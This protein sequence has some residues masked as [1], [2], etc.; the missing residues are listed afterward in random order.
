[1]P[2]QIQIGSA[3]ALG[4]VSGVLYS[5]VTAVG[6]GANTTLTALASYGIPIGAFVGTADIV[7]VT[8]WGSF[9]QNTHDRGMALQILDNAAVYQSIVGMDTAIVPVDLD[10]AEML[11]RVGAL[12][13]GTATSAKIH[14]SLTIEGKA[15]GAVKGFGNILTQTID[16]TAATTVRIVGQNA[17]AAAND[18]VCE[19][20][21]VEYLSSAA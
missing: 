12:I 8:A 7:R 4:G 18:V 1:M 5:V 11:W 3:S 20:M 17:T 16:N 21:L 15:T 9:G 14:G 2:Q 19:G 6:T 10:T 13:Y